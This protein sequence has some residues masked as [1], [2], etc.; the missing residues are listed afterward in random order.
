MTEPNTGSTDAELLAEPRL[1]VEPGVAARV[2]AVAGPVLEGMGYRLVRIRISGE[3]G[4][5]VQIMAERPDGSM[6]L[7][8][9]EAI[10]RALSPVLDVADPIDRAYR[11][12]VSSPGIDRPLVRRSDFER[13]S[14]HLVKIDMAVAHEGRKRFRGKLGAVEGDRVHLRRDDAK[15][16]DNP[17]VL[18]TMEDIGE[19]RLVL[20]DDLIA[21]SMRRG[22][23]EERQ[24]RRNLGLEPPAAPHAEISAK[25][26]KNTKPQKKPAP[27]NTKKHRLAAER[28]RR[29][30]IEPDE[31]D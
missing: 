22:K 9:C 18:L 11:L 3:A 12:E 7:E 1:V 10:S 13:Y 30:E 23:A 28:A 26:T 6:Q 31:G 16:S 29:G 25:I 19:A 21:E 4:C 15:A 17:D 2:S 27:T 5:T 8:D 20:T 24:M 14:G